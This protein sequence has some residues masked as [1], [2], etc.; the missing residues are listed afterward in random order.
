MKEYKVWAFART[1][2]PNLSALEDQL[3][4]V[5]REANRRGSGKSCPVVTTQVVSYAMVTS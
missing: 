5:M 2:M 3:A 4:D 1:A